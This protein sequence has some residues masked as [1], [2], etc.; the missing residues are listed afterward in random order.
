MNVVFIGSRGIPAKYGGVEKHTE[1]IVTRLTA[2]GHKVV[3][4]CR[5]NY[6]RVSGYYKGVRVVRL[7]T[8]NQKHLEMI[9]HTFFSLMLLFLSGQKIDIIHIQ[10]VD[11]AI[12]TPLAKLKA[13]VV[14]T[15]HGQIY[16]QSGKWGK[17]TKTFSKLAEKVFVYSPDRRIAVSK[18]LKNY[19]ESKYHREVIYIPNG[20]DISVINSSKEIEKFNLKKN[21]YILYVGRLLSTKGC[22]FLIEAYKRIKTNKKLVI[23]GGGAYTDS[24][25]DR[26]K[27]LANKNTIFLGYRFGKERDELYANA[28]GCVVP[29]ERE[30]LAMTLLEA[31]SFGKCVVYSDIPENLEVAERVGITF[32][33]GDIEDLANK[34]KFVLENPFYCEE[35]GAKAKEHVSDEYNWDRIVDQTEA[36]YHS[37][38]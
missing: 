20:V 30:G 26:L 25:V 4:Y 5:S 12:L 16:R 28:Y 2:K 21:E 14:V 8:L 33:S 18:T 6:N 27:N 7:P 17:L 11:P 35:L 24:Y 36:V 37:L 31:M 9:S 15:S 3:V 13:K 19:Y 22:H 1:E 29:S 34:L 38:L 10:S 23:V 32:R